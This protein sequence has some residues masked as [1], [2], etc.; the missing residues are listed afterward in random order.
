M[1][2]KY[3]ICVFCLAPL[4]SFAIE[5]QV[6]VRVKA[7]DAKFVGS[8]VGGAYVIIRNSLTGEIL[9]QGKTEGSTGNTSLIMSTPQERGINISDENTS[10]FLANLDIDEPIFVRIEAYSPLNKKQ[11]QA[12]ISTELWVIPGKHILGDGVVLEVSG[13]IVD[14]LKPQTHQGISLETLEEG[15][16]IIQANIVMM[17][18]CTITKGGLWDSE[19]IEVKAIINLNGE[20]LEEVELSLISAN[21]FEG[22]LNGTQKGLYEI[23]LYAYSETTGNTG[24]DK[25]NFI[26]N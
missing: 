12:L 15:T 20:Y 17:C 8:S 7:K 19:K 6:I 11:A 4:F 24:V 21:L 13:F 2:V 9:S 18:G 5:T 22:K 25:M 26:L 14:I 10:K 23:I 3:L 1:K 16:V